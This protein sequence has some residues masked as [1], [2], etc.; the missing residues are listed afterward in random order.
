[1][2]TNASARAVREAYDRLSARE[3][4]ERLHL[5]PAYRSAYNRALD[6]EDRMTLPRYFW[7]KWLPLLGAEAAA[8]YVVLRDMSRVEAAR[9]DSWCWPEQAE[10][11]LRIGVSKNTLRK[12]LGVLERHGFIRSERRRE[13]LPRAWQMVQG[14][15][16]YE[17]YLDIPLTPEDAV[18]LLL[19]EIKEHAEA[20]DFRICAQSAAPVDK[21]L[22]SI[23]ALRASELKNCTQR[24]EEI[25]AL[26]PSEFKICALNVSNE[27][28]S[29]NVRG[30]PSGKTPLREHPAVMGLSGAE[31]RERARLASEIGETLQRMSGACDGGAHPSMGFHRRV[32]FLMP[33]HLV[34]EALRATRDGVDD[35]RAGR[36]GVRQDPSQ[37]FG[38]IVKQLA[39]QHGVDLG[40]KTSPKHMI[41]EARPEPNSTAPLEL[42]ISP[43]E[44]ARVRDSLRQ[45]AKS[46]ET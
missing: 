34:R 36:G 10:L 25:Q 28:N 15:N 2:Y 29:S 30:T 12:A 35:R 22:S 18:E 21:S 26:G 38:G 7:R 46:F 11:G 16:R 37:Y 14:T 41:C 23:S 44:R 6:N 5:T 20:T 13:Q 27:A 4:R 45:L 42:K 1:M 43:E 31:K 39:H 9:S 40:L 33:V 17:V 32:A 3:Q 19:A 24:G 8:L